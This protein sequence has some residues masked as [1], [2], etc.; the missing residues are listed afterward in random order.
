MNHA[1]LARKWGCCCKFVFAQHLDGEERNQPDQRSHAKMMEFAVGVPQHIVEESGL[2]VP[3]LIGAAAHAL[4]RS[5]DVDEMLEEFDRKPFVH[6]IALGQFER[7]AHHG[8]A[9]KSHPA[10]RVGLLQNRAARQFFAAIHDGDVVEPEEAALEDV[11]PLAVHFVDPPGEIDQQF[12]KAALEKIQ[13]AA[14]R[15]APLDLIDAPARPCLHRR[16]QIRELPLV[17]RNLPVR[18]LELLEQQQP[19][20]FLGRLRDRPAPP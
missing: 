11:Q 13:I 12:V 7:D 16:I 17:G 5:A 8:E 1:T 4:H 6:R 3:K 9:E 14:S 2:L 20:I 18:V 15:R 10:G 19:E